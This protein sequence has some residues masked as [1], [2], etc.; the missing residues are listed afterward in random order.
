MGTAFA[1]AA[2][3]EPEVVL[4]LPE[5]PRGFPT[6][7]LGAVTDTRAT[8]KAKLPPG[9]RSKLYVREFGGAPQTVAVEPATVSGSTVAAFRLRG[10][11]PATVYTYTLEVNGRPSYY[12]PGRLRTFPPEG[13]PA[14]VKF[15]FSSCARTGSEH[16]VFDTIRQRDPAV[17][18]HLGDFHY[19][20]ISRAEPRIFRAAWDTVLSSS[21]QGALYRDVP[22]AYVWDDHDFGPKSW[23]SHV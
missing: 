18:L 11:Q 13:R 23:S 22:L 8:V 12:P 20:N 15:A 10:L 2:E 7:W 5:R 19:E 1:G 6:M 9:V 3:E 17:F 21:T 14:S 16:L 4:R